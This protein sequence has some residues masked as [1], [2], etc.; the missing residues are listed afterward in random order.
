MAGDV[1]LVDEGTHTLKFLLGLRN[2]KNGLEATVTF[3]GVLNFTRGKTYSLVIEA[4]DEIS[5]LILATINRLGPDSFSDFENVR[6]SASVRE[7]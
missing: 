2:N 5:R 4:A 3:S 6:F 7:Y 1:T